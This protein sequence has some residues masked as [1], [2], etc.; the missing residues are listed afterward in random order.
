MLNRPEEISAEVKHDLLNAKRCAF[1]R[2]LQYFLYKV[3][4]SN[5]P[6]KAKLD[7]LQTE[8][9]QIQAGRYYTQEGDD[10][11]PTN[12]SQ[13]AGNSNARNDPTTSSSASPAPVTKP[14]VKVIQPEETER[15]P[16]PDPEKDDVRKPREKELVESRREIMDRLLSTAVDKVLPIANDNSIRSLQIEL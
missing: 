4:D 7:E 9:E 14:I 3:L 15:K 16:K 1:D 11:N 5:S 12:E 13:A 2:I 6:E 8:I 10:S